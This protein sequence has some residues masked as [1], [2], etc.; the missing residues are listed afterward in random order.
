[1]L[2]VAT[3]DTQMLREIQ[4]NTTYA[5]NNEQV[6]HKILGFGSIAHDYTLTF[7][8]TNIMYYRGLYAWLILHSNS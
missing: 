7:S 8:A 3:L 6:K 2:C 1:M 4:N 5:T